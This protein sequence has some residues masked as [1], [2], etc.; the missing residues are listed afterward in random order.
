MKCGGGK[1]K[2]NSH[3]CAQK[4]VLKLKNC[5]VV[6]IDILDIMILYEIF[7][8]D[9]IRNVIHQFSSQLTAASQANSTKD[10]LSFHG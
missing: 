2:C 7:F 9:S 5:S 6:D 1:L 8:I 10:L 4:I 3:F